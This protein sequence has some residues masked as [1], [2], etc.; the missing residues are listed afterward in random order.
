[1]NLS[2]VTLQDC[3]DN[4]EKKGKAAILE[5]G[6]LKGFVSEKDEDLY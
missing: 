1:M 3:I 4:F 2:E 5:D 6:E